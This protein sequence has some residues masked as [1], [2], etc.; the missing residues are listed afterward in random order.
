MDVIVVLV[1]VRSSPK[2]DVLLE[3]SKSLILELDSAI[4]GV[5]VL[6]DTIGDELLV[7]G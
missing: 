2:I 5:S 3:D 1:L 4:P 7:V 6:L